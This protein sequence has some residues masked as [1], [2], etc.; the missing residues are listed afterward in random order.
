[1]DKGKRILTRLFHPPG[2]LTLLLTVGSTAGLVWVF[3]GHRESHP[4]AYGIYVLSF[5]TLC[6]LAAAAPTL[7]RACRKCIHGNPYA[8][9]FLSDKL[10]RRYMNLYI[11]LIIN[12]A[13]ALTKM[14]AGLFTRSG[15]LAAMGGY[16]L[17]LCLLHIY[18]LCRLTGRQKIEDEVLRQ[19][20]SWKSYLTCGW[21]ILVLNLTLSVMAFFAI[22][23]TGNTAYPE[24][25]IYAS[26]AYT[27]YRFTMVIIDTTKMKKSDDPLLS[28]AHSVDF[29]M[30]VVSIFTL[31]IAM[32]AVFGNEM[33]AQ[34]QY[35]MNSM[36]GGIVCFTVMC[37]AVFMIRYPRRQIHALR[38]HPPKY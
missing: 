5:Y 20:R 37:V 23:Q 34:T 26:A 10:L 30:A 3:A 14:G 29:C 4:L 32:F 12:L 22:R 36:T 28:A 17:V 24:L 6:V 33:A 18:L 11:G 9:R 21:L 7:L 2:I 35:W 27:F 25:L 15:W 31:Q 16:Y 38:T 8:S 1:M 19:L 13:Y